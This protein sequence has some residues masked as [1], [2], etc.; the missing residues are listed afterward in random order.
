M[1]MAQ[2]VV[3]RLD[4][5]VV[6]RLK[7]KAK[8]HGRSMEEE[9]RHVLRDAARDDTGS[10]RGLGSRIAARF[11]AVSLTADLPEG[12]SRPDP[13]DS[14]NDPAR[15]ERVVGPDASGS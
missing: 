15:H 4:D 13:R 14:T 6:A 11:G 9:V 2:L 3:R 1:F 12:G 8:Q 10:S 5:A 7:R